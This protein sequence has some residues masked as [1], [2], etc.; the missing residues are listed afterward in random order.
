MLEHLTSLFNSGAI[1]TALWCAATSFLTSIFL[2]LT[3][4]VHGAYTMDHSVGVQKFHQFATPRVGGL[5]IYFATVVAWHFADAAYQPLLEVILLAGLPAFFF[6]FLEDLIKKVNVLSRL[7]ATICSALVALLLTGYSITHVDVSG[8][9]TLLKFK[10][11]SVMFT[12]FAVAGVANA[13]NI[14]DGFNGLASSTAIL[15]FTGFA[16]I[17]YQVGDEHLAGLCLIL[18]ACVL[19]FF[20]V[21]WP[22]GKLFMGDGGSY[23]VGFSLAWVAVM[24]VERNLEVS[25]FSALLVCILPITEVIFSV[26]RRFIRGSP[27]SKPDN[28]HLHSLI[29]SR[30]IESFFPFLNRTMK[31][32]LTG[33]MVGFLSSIAIGMS[34]FIYDL[35]FACVIAC[36]VYVA[37]YM[38]LYFRLLK[39][40]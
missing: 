33:L 5:A 8:I 26:G 17:A 3:K 35:T 9:D 23:F 14:L 1:S 12:I 39:L 20:L 13:I 40:Q 36:I 19:G 25:P 34:V 32:S 4:N 31:N 16:L 7:I 21:N 11:V 30:L 24:L 29:R 18:S 27:I 37:G 22:F 6:G 15:A 2:V 28:S 10:F 38:F